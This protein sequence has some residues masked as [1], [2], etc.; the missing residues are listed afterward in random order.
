MA[1][2]I[3]I[4]LGTTNSVVAVVQGGESVVIPN[5]DGMRTTPS[6][7]AFTEKGERLVGQIAKRQAI[8]NPE[9]TIFSIKR[10]MGRKYNTPEVEHAKKR[11]P[12]KI[13]EAPNGD[14]HVEIRGKRYSPPEISAMILQKLKQSA[15][16]YLG[17]TVSDAVV[18]VPAYFNDSQRQATKDAGKIAGLNVLRIINEPTAASLAYGMD[19]KKEEKIAVYD[20]GGGTF[21]VSILEIGEGVIEVKS[22]NGD[23]YLGG[24]DFDI[25]I[26][27]WMVEEFKKDQGIDLKH[28]KMALQRLKEAAERAKIDLS[29]AM[30]TEIN[31]PFV[32][33]DA[34]GPKH[35]LMKL[36]RAK[37][38]QLAGDLIENTTGPCKNAL[39]DANLSASNIDEVLLVGGQ[40]RTPKVQ[41]TVQGFFG[42]EP[43]KT[44]NPDEVVAVGA[45]IQ[46]AVLKGDVKEVLLLDVTPLS[47]GI[48]TLG[49]IFTKIIERNTTIPTKKS[50]TFST[51]SDNQPAVTIKICQGEREMASDNKLLGN[52]ELIGIPPALRGIPQIEVTFDIDANG[53]LHVSAKDLGTGKEQSIRITASSG[54]SPD[55][56]KKMTR[57]A[58]SHGED[59]KN[60]KQLAEARNEAD[61]MIYS[62][63]KSLK[64]YGDKLSESEKKDIEAALEK[65][66]KAKDSSADASEIKS[67]VESLMKASH[68]LAEHIYKAAGDQ[69][70][71]GAGAEA[72]G[73]KPSEEDVV[74]A[75]FEDVDKDKK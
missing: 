46:G 43:N 28:D 24:D 50:Q 47:L 48:E 51:A 32:T 27:D 37:F 67:S 73:A 15:E 74:E 69:Q 8:T 18:T 49:G 66:K 44:V 25:K 20:L 10:L 30:E 5:Q 4:D 42:K 14:A 6:V 60:K 11:L 31:L 29:T 61:T 34:T 56:V 72:S 35:L 26:I 22:T 33:A 21:D 45:A 39:N 65:C 71:S 12:Y 40:T 19:K 63:E 53:I 9:N 58:E 54:L 41:Q 62:A 2:A 55:E 23:T 7:V 16:D 75:E 59:D 13:V 36:S 17:E 3:G 68:K 70:A 1:K 38:E 57:D 64:E 52:F